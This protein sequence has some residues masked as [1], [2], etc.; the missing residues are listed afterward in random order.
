MNSKITF[1]RKL[2]NSDFFMIAINIVPLFGVLFKG[3]DPKQMFL[4]Y[5]LETVIIGFYN[6]LKMAIVTVFKKKHVWENNGNM[7]M[8]SGWFFILFFIL[9]YGLFVTVQMSIFSGVSGFGSEG[10]FGPFS[11]VFHI[12]RYLTQDTKVVLYGFIL[13]YGL[14]TVME[15]IV[16]GQYRTIS[17]GHLMFQPYLRIFI[18]QFVVILG[19]MFI[20]FGGGKIFMIIF[21]II[22]IWFE[23]YI[24]FEKLLTDS[25]NKQG[26]EVRKRGLVK[27]RGTMNEER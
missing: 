22:K 18:Q 25:E 4:I 11:F 19:S 8:V 17:M 10:T 13:V 7:L 6:I 5:C 26:E 2:T 23:L 15:F 9:H 12:N 3:W 16:T 27:G 24:N 20:V 1:K 21:V 14:R